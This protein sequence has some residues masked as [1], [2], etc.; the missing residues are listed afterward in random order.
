MNRANIEQVRGAYGVLAPRLDQIARAFFD[1]ALA[2]DPSLAAIIPQPHARAVQQFTASIALVWK[3]LDR[4]A[5][6]EAP[7]MELGRRNA[8]LG[9]KP[10]H[11][12]VFRD[13]LLGAL[14]QHAGEAWPDRMRD[15]W[16]EVL[17]G[18]GSIMLTGAARA[19]LEAAQHLSSESR[20]WDHSRPH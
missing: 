9:V 11:Y 19:A 2:A 4:L 5:A 18:I 14:E 16:S 13:A 10:A 15:A 12:P 8:E 6:L 7:L 3:N 20:P 1:R 17:S